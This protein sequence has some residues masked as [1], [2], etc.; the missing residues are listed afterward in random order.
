MTEKQKEEE[1]LSKEKQKENKETKILNPRITNFNDAPKHLQR[2]KFILTGYRVDYDFI[3]ALKS[4]FQNHNELINSWSHIYATFMF[5]L[6]TIYTLNIFYENYSKI[7]VGDIL[8]WSI[9][10]LSILNTFISS[11]IY[12]LFG[13]C[14]HDTKV[15]RVCYW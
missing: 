5:F 1:R 15:F 11:S 13:L 6:F 14:H 4:L 3:L 7:D 2:N 9:Y 12:H 8:C 10:L